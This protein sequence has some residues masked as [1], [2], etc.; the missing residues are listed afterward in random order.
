MSVIMFI[1]SFSGYEK[2][3][4]GF[5]NCW[6]KYIWIKNPNSLNCEKKNYQ[7]YLILFPKLIYPLEIDKDMSYISSQNYPKIAMFHLVSLYLHMQ[8]NDTWTSNIPFCLKAWV[9]THT[10]AINTQGCGLYGNKLYSSLD[11]EC[12]YWTI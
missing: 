8:H 2:I 1:V 3:T 10:I 11:I 12:F 6:I 5:I 4:E 9:V 7:T